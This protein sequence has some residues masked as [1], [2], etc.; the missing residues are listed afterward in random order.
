MKQYDRPTTVRPE[1]SIFS[2]LNYF[3]GRTPSSVN[4][5]TPLAKINY[6]VINC[7]TVLS[8]SFFIS[9][10]R[11]CYFT[12]INQYY[13]IGGQLYLRDFG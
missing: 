12:D 7:D 2:D 13:L 5:G 11:K 10:T 9:V 4:N 3:F 8:E 1:S 6:C